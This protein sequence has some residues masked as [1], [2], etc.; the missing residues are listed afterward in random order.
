VKSGTPF[1]ADALI[2]VVGSTRGR[3]RVTEA[4]REETD[5]PKR[6]LRTVRSS[7]R[8]SAQPFLSTSAQIVPGRLVRGRTIE[9]K[10]IETTD[11][12]RLPPHR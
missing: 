9:T 7:P 2:P 6:R 12:E 8:K 10:A 11:D 1:L 4:P 5:E 3:T